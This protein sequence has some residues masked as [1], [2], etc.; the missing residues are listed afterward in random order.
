M[1]AGALW[2][3]ANDNPEVQH[4]WA[5]ENSLEAYTFQ[6]EAAQMLQGLSDDEIRHMDGMLA[7]LDGFL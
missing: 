3:N 1:R 7:S 4:A 2:S 5:M 6:V